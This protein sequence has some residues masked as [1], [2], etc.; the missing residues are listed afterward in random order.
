MN[1]W[2]RIDEN[3]G[4]QGTEPDM[5]LVRAYAVDHSDEAFSALVSRHLDF[6][7]S[8]ALRQVGNP[9]HAEEVA[10]AVFLVLSR[11]A[12][13]LDSHTILPGWLH[14][15]TRFVSLDHLKTER[16]R[17]DRERE[18]HLQS[19]ARAAES[20]GPA[21]TDPDRVWEQLSP[22]LDDAMSRLRDADRDALILRYFENKSLVEVGAALG[23]KERA[24]QKR[25]ARGLE[26]LRVH[27]EKRGTRVSTGSLASVLALHSV[28]AAPSGLA[29]AIASGVALK[30]VS[31][32]TLALAKGALNI[33][34][35]TKTKT[36][37]V[38]GIGII[39]VGVPVALVVP[40]VVAFVMLHHGHG[41]RRQ[42]ANPSATLDTP[43][44]AALA[45]VQ[46]VTEGRRD[47]FDD[48]VRFPDGVADAQ[49]AALHGDL[50]RRWT[51]QYARREFR[52]VRDFQQ[53]AEDGLHR[54][55]LHTRDMDTGG[56]DDL[57][58]LLK[59]Y[60][61]G[62]RVYVNDVPAGAPS[63]SAASNP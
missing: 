60:P 20:N 10:Q 18:A 24:A 39:L 28:H 9:A 50:F 41:M 26:K 43:T 38:V 63:T 56:E 33:M 7:Y 16:R 11:K 32:P 27:F 52:A 6:V 51:S 34:A 35:W 2:M 31:F 15:T 48:L 1:G 40:K 37:V 14:R 59:K 21:D 36:A 19:D 3:G 22:L 44:Q 58:M 61:A 29:V 4:N 45:F 62:W 30:T 55:H 53:P 12:A 46:A 54:L 47:E 23:L 57:L 25:V 42:A 13:S 8:A 5:A 17:L 49:A